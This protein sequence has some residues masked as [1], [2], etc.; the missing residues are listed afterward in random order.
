MTARLLL[1]LLLLTGCAAVEKPQPEG[2]LSGARLVDELRDGGYVIVVRHTATEEGGVDDPTK[3]EDCAPQRELT[4]EGRQQAR[5]LGKAIED[6]DVPVGRVVASPYCR[7]RETAE[8]AFGAD[9]VKTD[10]VLLPLPGTGKPGNDDAI[11]A[12]RQLL[13]QDT[14]EDANTV[15]VTHISVIEPV[16]GATPEEGGSAV[17]VPEGNGAFRIVAEVPPGGWAKLL[18]QVS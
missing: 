4:D 6:L 14:P 12:A 17:F 8:L 16:T 7:T 9:E 5:D 15:V 3:L 2:P 11:L 1:C 10:E 18:E 13:G